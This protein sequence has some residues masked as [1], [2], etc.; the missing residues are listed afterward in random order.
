MGRPPRAAENRFFSDPRTPGNAEADPRRGRP[1]FDSKPRLA[2]CRQGA[3]CQGGELR[4]RIQPAPDEKK[5]DAAGR[6]E[7]KSTTR[8]P[9]RRR[10]TRHGPLVAP[11]GL[12]T[13]PRLLVRPAG[14]RYPG[15]Q[16]SARQ[17]RAT[18]ST[19][20]PG[21]N[22]RRLV[23][24]GG[25]GTAPRRR[26]ALDCDGAGFRQDRAP[27]CGRP[28]GRPTADPSKACRRRCAPAETVLT[29]ETR[30][31]SVEHA[32]GSVASPGPCTNGD[33]KG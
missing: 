29:S 33:R 10:T 27:C 4:R 24:F 16:V 30:P 21:A 19:P 31:L 9:R 12:G 1:V 32:D 20:T 8:T 23:F 6:R 26:R 18:H 3:P 14:I 5:R 11:G 7:G 17:G 15:A 13:A 28:P 25:G 22:G 2:A